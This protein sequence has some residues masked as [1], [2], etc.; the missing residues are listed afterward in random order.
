MFCKVMLSCHEDG[1]PKLAMTGLMICQSCNGQSLNQMFSTTPG[2]KGIPAPRWACCISWIDG[3]SKY[4]QSLN[5]L[6]LFWCMYLD[7]LATVTISFY[8]IKP[9]TAD[10][11]FSVSG[12]NNVQQYISEF[13]EPSWWCRHLINP[14]HADFVIKFRFRVEVLCDPSESKSL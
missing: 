6:E 4:Q 14:Y 7:I 12:Y 3:S 8:T 10:R 9:N 13:I 11:T 1:D 5:K 2:T